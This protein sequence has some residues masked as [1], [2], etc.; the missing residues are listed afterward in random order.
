MGRVVNVPLFKLRCHRCLIPSTGGMQ[1]RALDVKLKPLISVLQRI[2]EA[3][4]YGRRVFL[5]FS[6]GHRWRVSVDVCCVMC[7]S[8]L[9]LRRPGTG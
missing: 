6:A 2:I 1:K 4:K 5:L 8:A 9:S 7:V 3:I